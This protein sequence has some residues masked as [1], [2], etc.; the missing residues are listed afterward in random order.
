MH[1]CA[2][3]DIKIHTSRDRFKVYGLELKNL[4][5]NIHI[6]LNFTYFLLNY[7]VLFPEFVILLSHEI[8]RPSANFSES[9]PTY[10]YIS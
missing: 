6:L 3:P 2:I 10:K 5:D 1:I 8:S 9:L 7:L 4:S